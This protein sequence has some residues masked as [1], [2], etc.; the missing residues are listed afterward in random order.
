MVIQEINL[1]D[2]I[3]S[4]HKLC[5]NMVEILINLD[6]Q[7][8]FDYIF[9]RK[10]NT[11]MEEDRQLYDSE[12]LTEWKNKFSHTLEKLFAAELQD[13]LGSI[14]NEKLWELGYDGEEP[15]PHTQNLAN[16]RAYHR[17]LAATVE[18]TRVVLSCD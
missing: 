8:D 2:I 14:E 9:Y 16:L 15:N 11:Q 13:T 12:V 4:L 3:Q 6:I 5:N 7:V 10:E 18:S 1:V 17:W